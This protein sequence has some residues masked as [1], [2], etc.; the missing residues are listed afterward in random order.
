MR[1]LLYLFGLALLAKGISFYPLKLLRKRINNEY[2]FLFLKILIML[3]TLVVAYGC[4]WLLSYL[5]FK[6]GYVL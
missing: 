5:K 1:V 3:I 4:L 2:L 6:S